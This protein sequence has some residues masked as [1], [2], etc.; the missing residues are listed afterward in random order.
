MAAT[1]TDILK[2]ELLD[3]LYASYTGKNPVDSADTVLFPAVP[4]DNYW[5]GIGK[6]E[7]W[8]TIGNPP[9]PNAS[10]DDV[11]EFQSSLQSAKKVE[12][13]SYVI[14][15]V[16]WS[17]GSIYTAWDNDYSSNTTIGTLNDIIGSYYV[18]TDQNNVY[19]CIEQGIGTNG[20][21]RN[22]TTKPTGTTS[23]VFTGG[24]GYA[25][26]FMYNVGV[27]TARRYL[28]SN[29]IPV[30]RVPNPS[31]VDGKEL[32]QLSF[33]RKEQYDLQ[34]LA[35]PG[36]VIGI[37]VDSSGVGYPP[38]NTISVAVYGGVTQATAYARTDNRGKIFQCVMKDKFDG[39]TT[40]TLGEG[41]GKETWTELGVDS[42]GTGTGAVLRPIVCLNSLGMGADPRNDL[43]T[44]ALMYTTRLVGNEYK[45]F[46]VQN[47]FR[48]FGLIKN[49]MTDS[50][51]PKL[52]TA[53][54]GDSMKKLYV[55]VSGS[56]DASNIRSNSI[57]YEVPASGVII[58][59]AIIDYYEV[60]TS[61]TGIVHCH[62]NLSTG[63]HPFTNANTALLKIAGMDGSVDPGPSVALRPGNMDNFSGKV[64]YIDN[65]V[66][67]EREVDQT[68][69]IKII[70]DL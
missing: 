70:I 10:T 34:Q 52:L 18:I 33:S 28:T 64:L 68:E 16:N 38:N 50:D 47:D 5:I 53:L 1:I 56:F 6:A 69:D 60:L 67:I 2:R 30:E 31:D 3:E 46:N 9:A 44:S 7:E 8:T 12:D 26:K 11:I 40:Y 48:Q 39:A 4:A 21:V 45:T 58:K 57:V 17:A 42:S 54:R 20:V 62:Q 59:K 32:D 61:T 23:S 22:S 19:I 35:V 51:N 37:A 36:Q 43:N 65:R 55:T 25:W 49:L 41:Y 14:P 29:Y 63:Y 66:A 15:R 13:V 24:D 27:F